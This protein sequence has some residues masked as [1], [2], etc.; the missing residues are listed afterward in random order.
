MDDVSTLDA[1]QFFHRDLVAI[2][3]GR[4]ESAES[5]HNDLIQ[6]LF[7]RELARLYHRPSRTEQS[8]TALKSGEASSTRPVCLP[9]KTRTHT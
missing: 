1:L 4:P 2:R 6:D 9:S 7:K 3:E 5:F 8:R